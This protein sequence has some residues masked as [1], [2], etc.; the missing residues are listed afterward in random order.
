[1]AAMIRLME[2]ISF[3]EVFQY[4]VTLLPDYKPIVVF[5]QLRYKKQ[6][7]CNT[8]LWATLNPPF[9]FDKRCHAQAA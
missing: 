5:D 9:N 1:M 3:L 4:A 8:A 2:E 7:I 6:N